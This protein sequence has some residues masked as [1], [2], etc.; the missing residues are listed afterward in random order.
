MLCRYMYSMLCR[1]RLASP[2]PAPSALA[3][4]TPLRRAAIATGSSST[5]TIS[6]LTRAI[7]STRPSQASPFVCFTA[8]ATS[9]AALE[10]GATSANA[11]TNRY[12]RIIGKSKRLFSS[13]AFPSSFGRTDDEILHFMRC[14]HEQSNSLQPPTDHDMLHW[15]PSI[16]AVQELCIKEGKPGGFIY[17]ISGGE[18]IPPEN[19]SSISED[20]VRMLLVSQEL[21]KRGDDGMAGILQA[22]VTTAMELDGSRGMVWIY[23][24]NGL[25]DARAIGRAA[26]VR[27][28]TKELK[29]VV[30]VENPGT[31]AE[32][33][34]VT[35]DT[36][37]MNGKVVE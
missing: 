34:T 37:A 30:R 35:L 20:H 23:L 18:V 5:M 10:V 15:K 31:P 9:S 16:R 8:R 7:C 27:G 22:I 28:V 21:G 36:K 14:S 17:Y 11:P 2:L 3:A 4:L 33:Y 1:L 6:H 25:P 29:F 13:S 32:A 24:W 19:G 26:K 12:G